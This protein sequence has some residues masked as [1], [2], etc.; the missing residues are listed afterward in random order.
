MADQETRR[1]E[2]VVE[3]GSTPQRGRVSIARMPDREEPLPA[4]TPES[5][6]GTG[7]L[8]A[9]PMA[10]PMADI[11]AENL[12]EREEVVQLDSVPPI[13]EADDV[14]FEL[15]RVREAASTPKAAAEIREERK[16]GPFTG[17]MWF[18]ILAI[19]NFVMALI[20]RLF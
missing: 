7:D 20:M 3:G 17:S 4:E 16:L 12:R 14:P 11:S 18:L 9:E 6:Q 19:F 15:Q 13:E 5:T 1:D 10:E 8:Q 2:E